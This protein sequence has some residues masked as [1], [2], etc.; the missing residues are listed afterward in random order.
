M[1]VLATND[2]LANSILKSLPCYLSNNGIAPI[3]Q[4]VPSCNVSAS[5]L[6][7]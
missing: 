7:H 1:L 2:T 3:N 4:C 5:T 6:S